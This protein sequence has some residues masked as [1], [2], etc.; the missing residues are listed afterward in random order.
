ML[1][2]ITITTNDLKAVT[3]DI[4]TYKF[5]D[6]T[7]F[8]NQI[9]IAR[10]IV[11]REVL[12]DY[13]LR[14]PGDSLTASETALAN[15]KDLTNTPNLKDK[16]VR[17]SIAEIFKTNRMLELA[18]AYRQDADLITLEYHLDTDNDDVIDDDDEINKS[19]GFHF[20]R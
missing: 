7:D 10:K 15:V 18:D 11:Y 6:E 1:S 16:I 17:H 13:R 2:N 12:R 3:P 19:Y 20:G 9:K 8:A 5:P 14:N 4:E